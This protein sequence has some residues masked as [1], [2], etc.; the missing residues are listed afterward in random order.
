MGAQ[1]H[2][3]YLGT[4]ASRWH[5]CPEVQRDPGVH[6]SQSQRSH[7]PHRKSRVVS[8]GLP[9]SWGLHRSLDFKEKGRKQSEGPERQ[10]WG[11][12]EE[13]K[14]QSEEPEKQETVGWGGPRQTI[15]PLPMLTRA[16]STLLFQAPRLQAQVSQ[17]LAQVPDEP[18][19]GLLRRQGE[20]DDQKTPQSSVNWVFYSSSSWSESRFDS[21]A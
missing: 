13:I 16:A 15:L 7:C 20:Q 10:T 21:E 9:W 5:R 17:L 8:P 1:P 12:G 11:G 4:W 18:R 2:P 3:P 19:Q 14:R 6:R